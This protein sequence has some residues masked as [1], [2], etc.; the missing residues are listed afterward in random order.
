MRKKLAFIGYSWAL[1]LGGM[2]AESQANSKMA[3]ALAISL[4]VGN[5]VMWKRL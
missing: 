1:F 4:L 2:W 5:F 3:I